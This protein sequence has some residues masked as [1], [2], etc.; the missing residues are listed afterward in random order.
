MDYIDFIDL[1]INP[2]SSSTIAPVY[3]EYLSES[4]FLCPV[5]DRYNIRCTNP[6]NP[7]EKCCNFHMKLKMIFDNFYIW[8]KAKLFFSVNIYCGS[9]IDKSGNKYHYFLPISE[10]NKLKS[11][12]LY[13]NPS[14]VHSSDLFL[15]EYEYIEYSI[16]NTIDTKGNLLIDF[17]KFS[18]DYELKLIKYIYQL[19]I[20]I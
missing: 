18:D 9:G 2:T 5:R 6:K 13:I 12:G 19:A 14:D 4:D 11:T 20:T 10:W 8:K 1:E 16:Y 7:Q 15:F 3:F 17:S